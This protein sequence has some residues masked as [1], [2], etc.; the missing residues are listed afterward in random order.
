MQTGIVY[1]YIVYVICCIFYVVAYIP[2]LNIPVSR[3]LG[4]IRIMM[5]M[6]IQI[7]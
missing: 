4:T 3:T 6:M 7:C 5:M 1:V 2:V